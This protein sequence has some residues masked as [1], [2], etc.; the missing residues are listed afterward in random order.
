MHV[1]I[2]QIDRDRDESRLCFR[3]LDRTCEIT[4][5]KEIDA[6]IYNEVFDGNLDAEDLEDVFIQFNTSGHPLYRGSSLSVSDVLVVNKGDGV[7]AYFCDSIGFAKVDFDETQ[8]HKPENLLRIVYVEPHQKPYIADVQNDLEHLQ[9]AVGGLIEVIYN[10]D[11]TLIVGN[12]ESKLNGM[13]GNRRLGQTILAGPFFV[14][15]DGGENFRS[16]TADETD[17]YMARFAEPEEISREE[18]E[19]DTGF[20]FIGQWF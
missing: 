2:Y 9:Q 15:G 11:G 5:Q 13:D 20:L 17:R 3:S 19:A 18:V 12:E 8:A 10:E 6:S 4:G 16:L 14:C 1:A 7:E